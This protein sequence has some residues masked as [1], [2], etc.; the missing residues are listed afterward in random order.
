M[1]PAISQAPDRPTVRRRGGPRRPYAR[2]PV[3]KLALRTASL[4]EPQARDVTEIFRQF[5]RPFLIEASAI[6]THIGQLTL[7]P[8][9]DAVAQTMVGHR[10][11]AENHRH[12]G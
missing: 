9:A 6:E 7:T 12:A 1:E 5:D 3:P 2:E 11:E 10:R 4:F 8:H